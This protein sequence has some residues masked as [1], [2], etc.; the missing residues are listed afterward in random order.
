[1][2]DI[3]IYLNSTYTSYICINIISIYTI[4]KIMCKYVYIY[5]DNDLISIKSILEHD[6][7]ILS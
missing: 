2:Q 7:D 6:K 3:D 4:Y 1:M 5:M